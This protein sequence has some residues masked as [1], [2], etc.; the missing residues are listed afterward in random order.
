[1]CACETVWCERIAACV[2]GVWWCGH[3]YGSLYGRAV[4]GVCDWH[5]CGCVGVI[6]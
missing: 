1:M 6:A 5:V 3:V 2:Y 4:Y